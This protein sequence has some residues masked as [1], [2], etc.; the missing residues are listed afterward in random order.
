MPVQEL[1]AHG[2]DGLPPFRAPDAPIPVGNRYLDLGSEFHRQITQPNDFPLDDVDALVAPVHAIP[3]DALAAEL[4]ALAGAGNPRLRVASVGDC[5]S[6]RSA[7]EA[8]FEGREA[9]R[10][11]GAFAA[12]A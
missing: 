4:S 3:D 6:A 9:G 1:A 10:A 7:L 5:V 12:G 2:Q 8:V 11:T